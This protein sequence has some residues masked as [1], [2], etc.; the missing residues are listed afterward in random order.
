MLRTTLKS[1]SLLGILSVSV[2]GAAFLSSIVLPAQDTQAINVIRDGQGNTQFT[3][4]AVSQD[5]SKNGTI[6]NIINI[7]L[8][9][10]GTAAVIAIIIAGITYTTAN[11]DASKTKQ[12]KD[13][14]MYAVIGLIVALMAW[15]IVS[16]VLQ[17]F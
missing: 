10:L 14:I 6:Q 8:F 4:D 9:V 13:T 16:F 11:G 1:I 15:G 2:V 7:L 12:A 5:I 17:Q 3:Q